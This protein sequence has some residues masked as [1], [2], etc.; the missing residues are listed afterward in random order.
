MYSKRSTTQQ[1]LRDKLRE[2]KIEYNKVLRGPDGVRGVYVGIR[3]KLDRHNDDDDKPNEYGFAELLKQDQKLS[4]ALETIKKTIGNI[5]LNVEFN[6][7]LFD[8]PEANLRD[9]NLRDATIQIDLPQ[10][11]NADA[12]DN[13]VDDSVLD[14]EQAEYNEETH[15]EETE[16]TYDDDIEL[17]NISDMDSLLLEF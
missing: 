7:K 17:N 5:K 12:D 15:D 13:L 9:A 11:A 1:I 4:D 6:V 10:D 8:T 2:K 16:S 3:E 14:A